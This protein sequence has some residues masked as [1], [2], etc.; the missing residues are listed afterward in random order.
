MIEKNSNKP[1]TF[2]DFQEKFKTEKDCQEYLFKY[3]W[4][5]GL[6][7]PKCKETEF[8]ILKS[9]ALYQ[10]KNSACRHQSSI[11]SNTVFHKTHTPLIKWFWMI[12]MI[13][14]SKTGYS[15]L[16]L[17]K[18]LGI[19]NYRTAWLMITK[20]RNSMRGRD[21]RYK[22]SGLLE[23]DESYFGSA[24]HGSKRGRGAEG[25][26]LVLVAVELNESKPKYAYLQKIETAS[27]E[28]IFNAVEN[29]IEKASTL[30]TD[31]WRAYLKA[32]ENQYDH[33]SEI[34]NTKEQTGDK[35]KWVHLLVAN[36]KNLIR[37]TH[38]GV[39]P[40]YLQYYLD[41]FCYKFNRRYLEH[42]ILERITMA[43]VSQKTK[44]LAELTA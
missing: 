32:D 42:R 37:G 10:C 28:N 6:I 16:R 21:D 36:C 12:Y 26:P 18:Q 11:T 38:H 13:G 19:R 5:E 23:L 25:R 33:I 43:C 30:K 39:F 29:K 20:I 9:R 40:K 27:A 7:C 24:K 44:T 17:Q 14:Y 4:G 8:C 1:F 3:K 34:M 41:E 31:G 2:F 15:I 22:L 35:M